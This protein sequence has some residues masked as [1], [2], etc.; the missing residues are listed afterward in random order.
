P[1]PHHRQHTSCSAPPQAPLP[2]PGR[3]RPPPAASSGARLPPLPAERPVDSPATRSNADP[4]CP[5]ITPLSANPRLAGT[6][7]TPCAAWTGIPCVTR[8]LSCPRSSQR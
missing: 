5:P 6:A 2:P 8:L 7:D 1:T 3:L 4:C